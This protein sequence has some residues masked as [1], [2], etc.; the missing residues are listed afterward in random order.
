MTIFEG[1]PSPQV[2]ELAHIAEIVL[3]LLFLVNF[4]F[5]NIYIYVRAKPTHLSKISLCETEISLCET[6][7]SAASPTWAG[8]K[9]FSYSIY[10]YMTKFVFISFFQRINNSQV[11]LVHVQFI[12]KTMR[13]H[14][15]LELINYAISTT[16][17]PARLASSGI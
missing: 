11:L 1:T 4:H 9:S 15:L 5:E 14:V 17:K 8:I 2:P 3:V 7:I 16:S 6:E 12:F 13:L 10:I